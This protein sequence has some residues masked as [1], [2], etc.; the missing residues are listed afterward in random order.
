[1]HQNTSIQTHISRPRFGLLLAL[2]GALVITPD[3]LMIRLSGLE[4]WSLSAW[5]GLLI[6][7]SMLIV[8]R[9]MAR[10]HWRHEWRQL[11]TVPIMVMICATVINTLTFNFATVETSITVVVTALATAPVLAAGLSYFILKETTS[12]RTWLAII[13]TMTG[14]FIVILNGDSATAAPTGNVLL[15]GGLGVISSLGIA[16]VFVWA[17]RHPEAPV[18]LAVALGTLGSGIIGLFGTSATAMMSGQMLPILVMGIVIMPLAWAC[19]SIAPR[20]TSPTNVSLFMLLEMV[21]GPV[22][23][24]AGTGETPSGMMIVGAC[25]VLITLII[26]ILQAAHDN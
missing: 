18:L 25:I 10:Q 23:V 7:I 16:I 2:A 20:H 4:G 11:R 3:T 26:Y 24:W 14:V 17:R 9:A 1:M 12:W 8:W 21:L 19:L 13:M 15:G 5:R 6:G 22:W